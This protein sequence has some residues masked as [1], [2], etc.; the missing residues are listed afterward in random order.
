VAKQQLSELRRPV[1]GKGK[2]SEKDVLA[3]RVECRQFLLAIVKKLLEKCPLKYAIVQ[4]MIWLNPSVITASPSK[5]KNT[6][7]SCLQVLV[8]DG[9]VRR[10]Q[11]DVVLREFQ[12]LLDTVVEESGCHPVSSFNKESDRLDSLYHSLL[13]GSPQYANLWPVV[14]FLLTLSNGQA[15]LERGFSVNK[16]LIVENQKEK[17]L[18]ARRLVCDHIKEV[19][20]VCKVEINK[21]M[22]QYAANAR[23]EYRAHL[24]EEAAKRRDSQCA[25]KRKAV[26]EQIV[27]LKIKRKRVEQDITSMIEEADR[28]AEKAER[29]Q[30]LTSISKS[31][32][33]RRSAKEK[34][35][36]L[37]ELEAELADKAQELRTQ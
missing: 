26:E 20:G 37:K 24:E 3:F 11:C 17:S 12:L 14:R 4:N 6:L 5:A 32:A 28:H 35:S 18:I 23:H 29:S 33:L 9:C 1:S 10:S 36:H 22:L 25:L 27:D 31:N 2:I 34:R 7:E 19:G 8:N 30:D 21:K 16:E 13:G 15:S